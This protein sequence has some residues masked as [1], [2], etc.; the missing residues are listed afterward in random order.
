MT[1]AD[2]PICGLCRKK[3]PGFRTRAV[4]ATIF[5][6]PGIA[7]LP[8][9]PAGQEVQPG[10]LAEVSGGYWETPPHGPERR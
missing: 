4:H 7:P 8:T 6:G 1:P 3:A 5:R 2:I 10:R 9:W